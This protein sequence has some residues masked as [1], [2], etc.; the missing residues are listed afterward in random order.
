MVKAANVK[1]VSNTTRGSTMYNGVERAAAITTA[2]SGVLSNKFIC[3]IGCDNGEVLYGF[4][5][6]AKQTLGIEINKDQV[7]EAKNRQYLCETTIENADAYEYLEKN[8]HINPDVFYY[9]SSAR[10]MRRDIDKIIELRGKTNPLILSGFS[11]DPKSGET[12]KGRSLQLAMAKNIQETY[13]GEIHSWRWNEG[14]RFGVVATQ[15]DGHT[16]Q[17]DD[18]STALELFYSQIWKSTLGDDQESIHRIKRFLR[19]AALK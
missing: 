3:E 19:A 18:I 4:S 13:G 11:L 16:V 5:E 1:V 8:P 2:L 15:I 10:G 7:E 14:W 17:P 6:I 9:W 12:R